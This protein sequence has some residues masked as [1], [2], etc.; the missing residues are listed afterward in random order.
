[1]SKISKTKEYA[2]RYLLT[3]NKSPSDIATELKVPLKT[4]EN[5]LDETTSEK[6]GKAKTDK[7]KD[8][9]IRQTSAKKQ[10][11]VSI[12]TEAAA[13]LSDEFV[14]TINHTRDNSG[15]IFRPRG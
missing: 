4:V 13:Q 15:H 11:T 2:V 1:M 9:M 14:K 12:M 6:T 7:T 5:I 10:N 8:L 3:Q